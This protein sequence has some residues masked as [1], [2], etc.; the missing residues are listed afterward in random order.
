V[1]YLSSPIGLGHVRRDRAIADELRRRHGDVQIDWLAQD[2]VT[3]VLADAGERIHPASRWLASESAHLTAESDGH[4]LHVMSAYRNMDEIMVANF[5]VFQEVVED[6][7]YDL[8]IG[9]EAWDVDHFWHEHPSLKRA[10]FAWL[11][12]FVGFLPVDGDADEAAIAADL[13]AEM[14]EHV[15]RHRRVRDRAVFVG[16]P[17]DV[18]PDRFGPGM[19]PIRDWVARHFDFSGYITG[20]DPTALGDRDEVRVRLGHDPDR[21]LVVVTVGGSGIGEHLLRRMADLYP[22]LADRLP[23]LQLLLVAGPRIDPTGLPDHDGLHI[24]T[25]V[26]DLH[27]HLAVCDL[28]V[29]QGGL[30]TT[31]ELTAAG[32]PF[33]YLPLARHFEQ[34][35]HV[36]HRLDRHR[37]GIRVDPADADPDH[38][39]DLVAT[40]AGTHPT[41]RPVPTDGAACAADLVADLI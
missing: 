8:V 29:V 10:P 23:G 33:I 41:Y 5:H 13:N 35:I 1:L 14:I 19:D 16:D 26:P 11:T 4:G 21:P 38:L 39:L 7:G 40:H 18:V 3:R 9:D 36:P 20:F 37:A 2:P 17:D 25:Y 15:T 6:G 22:R 31:M 27:H 30:T 24:R 28:A 12:D 34:Q 32:R